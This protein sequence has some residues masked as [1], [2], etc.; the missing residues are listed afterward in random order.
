[1]QRYCALSSKGCHS[2]KM[3]LRSAKLDDNIIMN[4]VINE[5][6]WGITNCMGNIFVDSIVLLSFTAFDI[7][8]EA[9]H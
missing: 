8:G 1:M 7:T 4:I 2:Q 9:I 6:C 3:I 5:Y